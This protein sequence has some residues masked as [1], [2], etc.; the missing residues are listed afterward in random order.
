MES[1]IN[2]VTGEKFTA[3]DFN[4]DGFLERDGKIYINKEQAAITQAVSVA[5]HEF[6]HVLLD[7]IE[8]QMGKEKFADVTQQFK[9]ILK[10]IV[11]VIFY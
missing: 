9:N 5:S 2:P 10:D 8:K 6:L 11:T 1:A 4:S 3:A 7:K